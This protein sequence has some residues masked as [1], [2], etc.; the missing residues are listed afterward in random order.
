MQQKGGKLD[1]V[2][3]YV[4][5]VWQNPDGRIMQEKPLARS[6]FTASYLGRI[7]A[8]FMLYH[9]DPPAQ[10]G[11]IAHTGSKKTISIKVEIWINSP[12]DA[13]AIRPTPDT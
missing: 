1:V 7:G 2:I 12:G 5:P 13:S 3:S 8:L 11:H 10:V 6:H 4:T 9:D